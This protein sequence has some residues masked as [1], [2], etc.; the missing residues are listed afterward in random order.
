MKGLILNNLYSMGDTIKST[1]YTTLIVACIPLITGEISAITFIVIVPFIATSQASTLAIQEDENSKW[2][3]LEATFPIKRKDIIKA[4]YLFAILI[5]IIGYIGSLLTILLYSVLGLEMN[6]L[7][8]FFAQVT[9]LYM[10]MTYVAIAFPMLLAYGA[11]KSGVVTIVSI[12]ATLMI[13]WN[14]W[15]FIEKFFTSQIAFNGMEMSIVTIIIAI[16]FFGFSYVMSVDIQANK[17][18]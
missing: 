18:F 2:N 10:A 11:E 9:G 8:L 12:V 13:R 17:E 15:W 6:Y 5:I 4:K 1:L 7:D 3:R 16:L 14:I